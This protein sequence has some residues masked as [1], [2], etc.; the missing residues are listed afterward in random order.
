M[1]TGTA[2]ELVPQPSQGGPHHALPGIG[3]NLMDHSI[4]SIQVGCRKPVSLYRRLNP[5]AQTGA[6]LRW[7]VRRDGLLASNHFECGAFLRNV[8]GTKFPDIQLG[9]FPISV[10]EGG[11]DFMRRH[12]FQIQISSQRRGA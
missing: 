9:V 10:L 8:A 7:R 12:G 6:V 2:P 3:Q 1:N 11:K 5:L 4:T